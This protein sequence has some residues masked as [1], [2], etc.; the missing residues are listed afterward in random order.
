MIIMGHGGIAH[1]DQTHYQHTLFNPKHVRVEADVAVQCGDQCE[2]S[3]NYLEDV[4]S[5]LAH[6]FM[7]TIIMHQA[8]HH[9]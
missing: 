6:L 5:N 2:W 9:W 4:G 7:A 8:N 1:S 3:K